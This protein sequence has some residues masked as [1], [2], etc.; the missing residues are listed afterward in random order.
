MS[1]P[2]FIADTE[3]PAYTALKKTAKT[4]ITV[5]YADK[6]VTVTY[7]TY[8]AAGTE[9]A[10]TQVWTATGMTNGLYTVNFALDGATA[11]GN[12]TVSHQVVK[13]ANAD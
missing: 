5:A 2:G 1:A 13:E 9:V 6:T 4:E 12:I 7:K 11:N 3:A 10:K 8:N